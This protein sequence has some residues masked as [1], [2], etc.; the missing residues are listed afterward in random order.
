[1]N[2]SFGRDDIYLKPLLCIA[3]ILNLILCGCEVYALGN[4][5]VKIYILKYYTFLQNLLALV[6]GIFFSVY[7]FAAVFL[8]CEI[9]EFMKGLRYV[10][11]CGLTA[12]MIIFAVFLSSKNINLLSKEDFINLSPKKANFIL[13][14]FCPTVSLLSFILF[15]R[16]IPLTASLWTGCA[17]LPSCLYWII[18]LILSVTNL[19]EAPYD[20][21]STKEG[22]KNIFSEVLIMMLLPLTFI[23]ISY[24]LWTVK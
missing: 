19:W 17:S 18:Y 11:T 14:Y 16:Q 20:F 3:L 15:E 12:T 9:P 23:L 13:H 22:K 6:V 8:D 1:M 2:L 10:A 24:V 7:L 5:K 21:T 4:I